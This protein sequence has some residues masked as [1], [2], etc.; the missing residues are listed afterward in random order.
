MVAADDR[1]AEQPRDQRR[2][3]PRRAGRDEVDEVVA[4]VGQR[5]DDGGD[6]RHADLQAGVEGDVDL[7]D[8][9]QAPV[10]AGSVPSTSTS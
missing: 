9:G 5:L 4:A 3:D 8:G 2:R 6:A 7:G 1:H 10:D